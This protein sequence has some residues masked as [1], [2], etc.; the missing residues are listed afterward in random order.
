MSP[1]FVIGYDW[2]NIL[3]NSNSLW[4]E[5]LLASS[6]KCFVSVYK[7]GDRAVPVTVVNSYNTVLEKFVPC[8]VGMPECVLGGLGFRLIFHYYYYST[9]TLNFI[10]AHHLE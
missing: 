9:A 1:C 6:L 10:F 5:V 7:Y 4:E 8:D 2:L 3:T